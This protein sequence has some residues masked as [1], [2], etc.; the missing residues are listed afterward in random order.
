M[1]RLSSTVTMT[2][3]MTSL[4]PGLDRADERHARVVVRE[5]VGYL[6]I[7]VAAARGWCTRRERSV[8]GARD[9]LQ[10]SWSCR[11]AAVGELGGAGV[12]QGREHTARGEGG[13]SPL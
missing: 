7:A 6:V 8:R 3:T 5:V 2:M 11:A 1:L 13:G 12:L 9:E 10:A 4:R